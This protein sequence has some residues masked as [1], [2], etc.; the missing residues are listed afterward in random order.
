MDLPRF[1]VRH[2]LS[3]VLVAA[4]TGLVAWSCANPALIT[5]GVGFRNDGTGTCIPF[6]VPC[7]AGF[8]EGGD[9][10]CV[11]EG[12]CSDGYHNGGVGVCVKNGTCSSGYKDNGLGTC[13]TVDTPCVKGAREVEDGNC[14]LI[15]YCNDGYHEGGFGTCVPVGDCSPGAKKVGSYCVGQVVVTSPNNAFAAFAL[16]WS[17]VTVRS[18]AECVDAGV[19]NEPMSN[20]SACTW[21]APGGTGVDPVNCVDY[22]RAVAYCRWAG[23]RLPTA[24]EFEAA[25]SNGG[26]TTYPWGDDPP[27]D[28]RVHWSGSGVR[29]VRPTGVGWHPGGATFGGIQDMAGN[30]SEWTSTDAGFST[31]MNEPEVICRGG[32]Y[33]DDA[34]KEMKA[35][36]RYRC[37]TGLDWGGLGFRCAGR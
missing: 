20:D 6:D 17:E 36:T 19:C 18:Y 23:K 30:V 22:S 2:P 33:A 7:S 1:V 28:S 21:E 34:A 9:N 26:T 3:T 8:V 14:R 13:V 16:D 4:F 25:A 11:R 15:G 32:D 29:Q 10:A 5:C 27:D 37:R 35:V 12:T 31:E 24:E